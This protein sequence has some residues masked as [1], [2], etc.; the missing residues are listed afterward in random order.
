[1]TDWTDGYRADIDY[2]YGYYTEL[3]PL[4]IKL[5]FL[6]M[7]LVPPEQGQ[8]C[9]LGFGQ[10]LSVN[11]HAAASANTWHGNDF[12]PAHAS[13]AQA[14]AKASGAN[15]YL[16]D[17]AFADFCSR[18]DLPDFDSIGLHG[19]WSWIND[20]NRT[21]IV[22]F[23]RRKLKVGGVLYISYNTQPGWT[24]LLPLRDLL[25]E[26]SE[27]MGT[28]GQ[29][30]TSRIEDSFAFVNKLFETNPGYT[31]ANPQVVDKLKKI[32]SQNLSYIAHEYFNQN[33]LPMS[34]SKMVQWL[35]PAKLNYA[36]S[37]NYLDHV[38]EINLSTEQQVLLK[39]LPDAMFRETVRDFCVNQQFRKDYW[40]KGA[41][42][43]NQLEKVEALRAVKIILIKPRSELLPN[44]NSRL[45]QI[46]LRESIY[47]PL[48]EVLADHKVQTLA[49]IERALADQGLILA[50]IIQAILI[51]T[52]LG[53]LAPVQVDTVIVKAKEYTD[54]LNAYLLDKARNRA[55][56]SYLA[57]PV[58]GGAFQV[59]RYQQLFLLVLS[60]GKK[61]PSEW[62]Q[63]VTELLV[64]Q[65]ATLN[66][67]GQ[68]LETFEQILTEMTEQAL[69]FAEHKLP[70]L[71]VLQIV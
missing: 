59:T 13:F 60:S 8:H 37:A 2:T 49:Q 27:V 21:I 50:Q 51:L 33:W 35:N 40:V 9:E 20:E 56:I 64:S 54:K 30:F 41:R 26:H 43:L 17:E 69:N 34:F 44:I 58:T 16:S 53:F 55:E 39:G 71:K 29:L 1:M 48:I 10:G 7:G 65:K 25:V 15:V 31:Q 23:I 18:S 22:N 4:F 11:M 28:D 6:N 57:S 46:S 67:D 68:V 19:I 5:A 45:G 61:Q 63:W 42:Q 24:A 52:G 66:K 62:A 47:K 14:V 3:N 32:K 36:C 38:D 70:I 12:N